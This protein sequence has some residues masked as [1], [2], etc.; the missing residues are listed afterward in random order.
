M[1]VWHELAVWVFFFLWFMFR[2]YHLYLLA[3]RALQ[4]F[5]S[6]HTKKIQYV[7]HTV[8]MWYWGSVWHV[9]P[10]RCIYISVPS[11]RTIIIRCFG[12]IEWFSL[13][14]TILSN[15]C[16]NGRRDWKSLDALFLLLLTWS[17]EGHITV[18]WWLHLNE[19]WLLLGEKGK[20]ATGGLDLFF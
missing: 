17:H 7:K 12:L 10:T 9:H 11:E 18:Q 2:W 5:G 3:Y 6:T 8:W 16:K 20:R 19:K 4:C 15:L 1:A 14:S 13:V